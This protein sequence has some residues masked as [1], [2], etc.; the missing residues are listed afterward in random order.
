[1]QFG[2]GMRLSFDHGTLVITEPPDLDLGFAPG[3]MWDARVAL[4]RAPARY[5]A[6]LTRTLRAKKLPL[7]DRVRPAPSALSPAWTEPSLRPYQ[8]GALFAWT[9]ADR[10]G[11]VVLPTGAGKTRVAVAALA[12]L[13]LPALIVVPTRALLAQW[14]AELSRVCPEPVGIWGDG[15][16]VNGTVTVATFESAYRLMPEHGARFDVL[17][18]DEVHHFGLGLRDE[19]LEMCVAKYRLGLTAT[20]PDPAALA[21]LEALVGPVVYELGVADLRG[22]YLADFD[23]VELR[24]P[25]DADERRRYQEDQARFAAVFRPFARQNPGSSWQDFT[26]VAMASAEGRAALAA[27]RRSRR[28]LSLTRKKAAA[29]HEILERHRSSKLLVFTAD[30]DAA[31]A[32]AR[33]EL[34]MPITCEIRRKERARVLAAFRDGSLRALVSSRV[35]N[36]GIDVPDADVAVIVGGT[37]GER[38][39]VQRIGRLLRPGPG[40]RATVYELVSAG[41]REVAQ[42]RERRR[43]LAAASAA[44]V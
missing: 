25:L 22:T 34:I 41:T 16:R 8:K 17:I 2:L 33:R 31:Y 5:H 44:L 20:P 1:M 32:I 18:V 43:G 23:L 39:H 19:L 36:E 15:E 37:R 38:E 4:W 24:L 40:K 28:L 12:E 35:L 26:G 7:D 11:L 6:E 27:W 14:H 29:V 13:R 30:N 3:L 10:R 42:S 21:R 9:L